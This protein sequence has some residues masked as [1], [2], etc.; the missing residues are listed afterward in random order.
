MIK[1]LIIYNDC[2]EPLKYVIVEGDYSRFD[3]VVINSMEGTGF[4]DEFSKFFFNQETG[5]FLYELSD[6]TDLITN[7]DWDYVAVTTFLP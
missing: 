5:A 3:G 1:T 6:S 4:E 2:R 7:K